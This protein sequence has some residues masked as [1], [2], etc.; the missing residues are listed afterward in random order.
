MPMQEVQAGD[1]TPIRGLWSS[2]HA[3]GTDRVRVPRAKVP[4]LL[5]KLE[6]LARELVRDQEEA[7]TTS[8]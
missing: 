2:L 4:P 3:K 1:R 8:I 5:E 6:F 7:L